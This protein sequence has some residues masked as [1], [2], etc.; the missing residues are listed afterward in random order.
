M[1][2][3]NYTVRKVDLVEFNE[4][5]AKMNGAYGKSMTRHQI[6]WPAVLAVAA[7]FIV[8]SA[9]EVQKGIWLLTGAFAWSLLIPSLIKKR[10]KAHLH[11]KLSDDAIKHA[12]GDYSLKITEEGIVEVKTTGGELIKWSA[13]E[14]VESSK[15]H[16]YLYLDDAATIIIPKEMVTEDNDFSTFYAEL[17]GMMKKHRGADA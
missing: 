11:D 5:H 4:Y 14:R 15:N 16:A 1:S 17:V 2:T 8:L 6:L 7:L 12:T 10:F 13:I 9:G 3:I